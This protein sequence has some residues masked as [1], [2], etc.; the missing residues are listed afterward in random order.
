MKNILLLTLLAL[1]L[2]AIGFTFS[3]CTD[4]QEKT[5]KLWYDELKV[6]HEDLKNLMQPL[7]WDA[8]ATGYHECKMHFLE[9]EGFRKAKW[10]E[11]STIYMEM[12][13][14]RFPKPGDVTTS[15][16]TVFD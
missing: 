7:L 12:L 4:Q 5:Y 15:Y 10:R 8:Y 11:D 6:E 2:S 16:K 9:Y 13:K 14:V 3:A 1:L